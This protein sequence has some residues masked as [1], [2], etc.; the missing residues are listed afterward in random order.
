MIYMIL[1]NFLNPK[2]QVCGVCNEKFRDY[3]D[4]IVHMKSRH[5]GHMLRCPNCGEEFVRES[6]RYH[7]IQEEKARKLD[8]RR[9]K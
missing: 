9:H 7:H 2:R 4:L 8:S 6:D 3:N 5:R 1:G